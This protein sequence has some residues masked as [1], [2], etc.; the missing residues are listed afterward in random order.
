MATAI[1]QYC[2]C[3][4]LM[5]AIAIIFYEF[6]CSTKQN[7]VGREAFATGYLAYEDRAFKEYRSYQDEIYALKLQKVRLNEEIERLTPKRSKGGKFAKREG[8]G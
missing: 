6:G 5:A 8:R 7:E 3:F 4:L 1:L 2:G